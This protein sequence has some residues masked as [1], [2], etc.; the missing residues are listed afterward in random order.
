MISKLLH[1]MKHLCISYYLDLYFPPFRS[2]FTASRKKETDN[3]ALR[4]LETIEK[5]KD[6]LHPDKHL[7]GS[8]ALSPGS[9]VS[10]C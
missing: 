3:L 9:E 8:S 5:I 10:A 6:V 1:I 2:V 7:P 4:A